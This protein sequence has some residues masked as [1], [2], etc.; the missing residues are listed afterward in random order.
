MYESWCSSWQGRSRICHSYLESPSSL[1]GSSRRR[2]FRSIRLLAK[3]PGEKSRS[4]R[5]VCRELRGRSSTTVTYRG[6]LHQLFL[7]LK[8]CN[9][10]KSYVYLLFLV[11]IAPN[12]LTFDWLII[13]TSDDDI[14]KDSH[15]DCLV[16]TVFANRSSL[17]ELKRA[18]CFIGHRLASGSRE[19]LVLA[20]VLQLLTS[21]LE[22]AK[23]G[24]STEDLK[25]AKR[26]ML[27]QLDSLQ[28]FLRE[29]LSD[30]PRDG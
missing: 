26:Y 29:P 18:I 20:N 12:R 21:L 23:T 6:M 22:T 13:Q 10:R 25:Q 7:T 5:P 3:Q 11:L 17:L 27:W 28:S 15:R 19:P 1:R 8:K 4:S 16:R 2:Y 24:L 9:P 30:V 14:V